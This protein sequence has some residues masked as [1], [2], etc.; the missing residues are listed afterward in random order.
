MENKKIQYK[1]LSWYLKVPVAIEWAR[2]VVLGLL[3]IIAIYFAVSG[4]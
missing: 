4:I 2:I 1:D 3:V